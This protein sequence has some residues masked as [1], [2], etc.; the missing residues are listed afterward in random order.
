MAPRE[1][2]RMWLRSDECVC[3]C[4]NEHNSEQLNEIDET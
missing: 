2:K 3:L 4:F 1:K